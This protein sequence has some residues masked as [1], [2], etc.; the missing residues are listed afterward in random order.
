MVLTQTAEYALRAVARLA[1]QSD[2]LP[3]RARD[4]AESTGIPAP[5]LAK[6]LR[7]L[8][9][10]GVL[11]SRRG[12]HGGFELA[13]DAERISFVDVLAAVDALPTQTRCV[14]G[15]GECNADLPCPLHQAWVRMSD[16]FRDWAETTT[17]ADLR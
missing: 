13:R 12:V 11:R 4:L 10:A 9:V 17:V 16:A 15:W 1:R 7:R 5:Y 6:I 3:Q 2:G 8:V 14:F